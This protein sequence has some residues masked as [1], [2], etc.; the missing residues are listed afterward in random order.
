MIVNIEKYGKKEYYLSYEFDYEKNVS[1]LDYN[2]FN[3]DEDKGEFYNIR[4]FYDFHHMGFVAFYRI[5]PTK[6][7]IERTIFNINCKLDELLKEKN[8][9]NIMVLQAKNKSNG[10]I[11]YNVNTGTNI[12]N[13]QFSPMN[14]T[15]CDT[16]LNIYKS[17]EEKEDG[18]ANLDKLL[19]RVDIDAHDNILYRSYENNAGGYY[20]LT[21]SIEYTDF[22]NTISKINSIMMNDLPLGCIN[23][24]GDSFRIRYNSFGLVVGCKKNDGINLCKYSEINYRDNTTQIQS[25]HPNLYDPFN[26]IFT[27]TNDKQY[28]ALDKIIIDCEYRL[29]A[30]IRT[31]ISVTEDN[32]K[33]II[34]YIGQ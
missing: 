4:S 3:A 30:F 27:A 14:V 11:D 10:F 31:V 20:R 23:N 15:I 21:D 32:Y 8:L 9:N 29:S 2:N 1:F 26:S 25:I 16:S 28:W 6:P 5:R 34:E 19:E 18:T 17:Y 24:T 22:D 12:I 33:D 7:P 13:L